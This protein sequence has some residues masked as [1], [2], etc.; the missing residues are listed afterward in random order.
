[1]GSRRV[2]LI[3]TT[4]ALSTF[5]WAP[6]RAKLPP[7]PTIVCNATGT[8]DVSMNPST[9]IGTWHLNGTGGCENLNDELYSLTCSDRYG[10]PCSEFAGPAPPFT[11]SA[12][13]TSVGTGGFCNGLIVQALK[14]DATLEI[15]Y[16]SSDPFSGFGGWEYSTVTQR[17]AI[18]NTVFPGLTPFRIFRPTDGQGVGVGAIVD[19]ARKCPASYGHSS[20]RFLIAFG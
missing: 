6:A 5:A 14:L 12:S 13:G 16:F 9:G 2:L 18:A 19:L 1:M 17:W 7:A 3:A 4:I 11:F 20:A 8:V 10:D 15:P